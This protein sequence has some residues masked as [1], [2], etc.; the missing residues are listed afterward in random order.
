[1]R[2]FKIAVHAFFAKF[3]LRFVPSTQ[4]SVRDFIISH[5]VPCVRTTMNSIILALCGAVTWEHGYVIN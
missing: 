4:K 3:R 1:M 2:K 5:M